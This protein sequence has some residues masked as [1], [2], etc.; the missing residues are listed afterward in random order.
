MATPLHH[1]PQNGHPDHES[2]FARFR[3]KITESRY[4][5]VSLLVHA[6]IV[7]IAGSIV[8]Y[9]SVMPVEDYTSPGEIV[10]LP[11]GDKPEGSELPPEPGPNADPTSQ[12]PN[13][14]GLVFDLPHTTA[15]TGSIPLPPMPGTGK[16]PTG[17]SGIGLP[18]ISGP[19]SITRINGVPTGISDIFRT[20]FMTK[21]NIPGMNDKSR[22]AVERSL[23]WLRENQNADGSWGD[24]NKSAMTGLALLCYLG[25][26][27]L[28]DS[29]QYGFTI[30]SA[31]Q[32]LL[33]NGTKFEGR[34]GM[35]TAFSKNGV[36]EHGIATYALGEFY[37]LTHDERVLPL[38]TQAVAHIVEGQGPGGGW[39]YGFDKT[40]NDL[41]VSGWQI[42]ALKAA[43]LTKLNLPGVDAALDKAMRYLESVQGP[44]GGYGYRTAEDRY[45]LS[46]VGILSRIFWK[47]ERGELRKGME[48]LIEET[49]KNHPVKYRGE[50]ADLYAWYYHTQ[51]SLMFGGAAWAKWNRWFQDELCA[52]QSTDGS[53][54]V[55]G[56]KGAGGFQTA[57]NKTG[58]VYRT[59]LCTLML[60]V[61]YRYSVVHKN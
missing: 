22:A 37:A 59:T 39:M 12:P 11:Q 3:R 27:E 35:E 48:W 45:S 5:M 30:A 49:E 24:G 53:W 8:L 47:G 38:L 55:A 41:S 23:K 34:L 2:A 42:Q 21:K 26:G 60:E 29:E 54:P 9:R 7:I 52:A 15:P 4:F 32:W 56:A 44:K 40:A 36:Y 50:S 46:G 51:A 14:G 17:T 58:A 16:I 28:P 19:G 13:V 57:E 20:R 61:F 10:G 33:D 43:Y 6:I 1:G 18:Q 31:V 25:F